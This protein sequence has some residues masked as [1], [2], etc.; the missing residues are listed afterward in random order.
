M[1]DKLTVYLVLVVMLLM[2]PM[3]SVARW[4]PKSNKKKGGL[5]GP[6]RVLVL[7]GSNVH[8]VGELQMHVGNWGEF[9]SRPGS[10]NLDQ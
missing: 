2:V 8:N 5:P 4:V 9:G 7:D 6:Q 10:G 3:S 1:R